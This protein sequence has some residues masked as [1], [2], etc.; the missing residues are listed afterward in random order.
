MTAPD[1]IV[2]GSGMGGA[3]LAAALAPTRARIL[4][5][6]RGERLEPSPEARDPD[7]IFGRGHFRPAEEWLDAEGRSFNPGNY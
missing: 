4:I 7:A 3:T 2:I 6:E 5:L 1:V